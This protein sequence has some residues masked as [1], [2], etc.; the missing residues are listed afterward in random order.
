[1]TDHTALLA[2]SQP[3]GALL[4]PP[5]PDSI[6]GSKY[7][8]ND[9]VPNSSPLVVNAQVDTAYWNIKIDVV[10]FLALEPQL[11]IW[12]LEAQAATER[13][14][15]LDLAGL[16][17]FM[18][19]TGR[20][21]YAYVLKVPAFGEVQITYNERFLGARVRLYSEWLAGAADVAAI[22][23]GGRLL[24]AGLF[25]AEN[26]LT[27]QASE[28]HVT[29]DVAGLSITN[30]DFQQDRFACRADLQPAVWAWN[31]TGAVAQSLAW[32][33]HGSPVSAALYDKGREIEEKS[34]HKAYLY[35]KWRAA[36]WNGDDRVMRVEFRFTRERLREFGVYQAVQLDPAALFAYGME[37][38]ELRVPLP[39]DGNKSR[40]A[41][42]PAWAAISE[43]AVKLL[44]EQWAQYKRQHVPNASV[45]ML[46]AQ[47]G[48]CLACVG[49]LA[50][51]DDLDDLFAFARAMVLQRVER[52][53]VEFAVAVADR[54]D[55][56]MLPL[57]RGF[58]LGDHPV[59]ALARQD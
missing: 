20:L 39:T 1:M 56:Y 57:V 52:T 51:S 38:L 46:T 19:P 13:R 31:E 40:W 5:N 45:D 48:G 26:I 36:G 9:P 8:N 4:E 50:G 14:K 17:Y 35:D 3:A 10:A 41:V 23:A 59:G 33:K 53:G 34:P 49:A 22:E 21:H 25:G 24:V 15:R 32:G 16:E 18:Q 6:G 37:W 43:Q 29:V 28:I 11:G 54:C 42:D 58:G 27:V 47:I 55:R 2:G 44:G 30:L 12:K 7:K